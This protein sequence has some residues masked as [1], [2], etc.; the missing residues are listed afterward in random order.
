MR[1]ISSIQIEDMNIWL[2]AGY[3]GSGK[4]TAAAY[5]QSYLP[6]SR[7]TAFASRVKDDVA[8]QYGFERSMLD[9]QEG[10]SSYI[11]GTKKTVRDCLIEYAA[12]HKESTNNPGIWALYVK[13]EMEQSPEVSHWILHDWRYLAEYIVLQSIPNARLHTVR[14]KKS[15]V[16]PLESASEHELDSTNTEYVLENHGSMTDLREAVRHIIESSRR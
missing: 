11:P 10:K 9:T 7:M 14:V 2:L 15:S 5:F 13:E 16:K 3:A 8:K 1:F 4:T 12:D 6:N